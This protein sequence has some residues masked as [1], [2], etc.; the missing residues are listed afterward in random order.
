MAELELVRRACA[1]DES[2]F[3]EIVRRYTPRVFQIARR[4]FRRRDR[5]EEVAQDVFLKAY[6]QLASYAE[7]GSFAGWLSRI[8]IHTCLNELRRAQ[9]H[10]E[11]PVSE[12]TEEETGWLE[13]KLAD[14]AA[15]RHMSAESHR[16]AVD[17]AE[18]VLDTLSPDD[19]LVLTLMDGDELSVKEIAEMTG[20][21]QAKVKIQSFR[22]R[23]RMRKAVEAL[24]AG[25]A[26]R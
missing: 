9:R 16:V 11:A 18:R 24:L 21:S 1:G 22:A 19:R 3:E 26:G 8:A 12:L 10:P 14:M 23:R 4:F 15:Q 2:S 20:W 6:T 5:I 13:L 7:R 17:L 25:R